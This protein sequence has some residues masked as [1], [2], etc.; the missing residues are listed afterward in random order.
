M[1]T[2]VIDPIKQSHSCLV[3]ATFF[4]ITKLAYEMQNHL[5]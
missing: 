4:S 1:E 2:V 5:A 3:A